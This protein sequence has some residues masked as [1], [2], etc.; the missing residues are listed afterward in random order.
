MQLHLDA[1]FAA[2]HATPEQ[3]EK[4]KTLM[5]RVDLTDFSVCQFSNPG[6]SGGLYWR[7]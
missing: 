2:P 3:I 6:M 1:N 4:A 5:K 7:I